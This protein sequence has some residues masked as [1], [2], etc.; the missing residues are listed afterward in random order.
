MLLSEH[1]ENAVAGPAS[2]AIVDYLRDKI[3]TLSNSFPDDVLNAHT[4]FETIR[5][6]TATVKGDSVSL[7]PTHTGGVIRCKLGLNEKEYVGVAVCMDTDA[8][9]G[10]FGRRLAL[11]RARTAASLAKKKNEFLKQAKVVRKER[12]SARIRSAFKQIKN[13]IAESFITQHHP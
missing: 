9:D 4:Y 2:L 11:F 12:R 7:H 13:S 3:H 10:D 1:P 8:F 5:P 6:K